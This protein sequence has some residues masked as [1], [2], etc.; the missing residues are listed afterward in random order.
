MATPPKSTLTH[1]DARGEARMVDVS[2]K[3]ATERLAVAEGC[4][5]MSEATLDLVM[6]GQA[7]KGDVLGTARIAGIMAAKRTSELIPL[8]HPLALSKVTVD[9]EPDA[10]LP[11]C[12]V[13]ATVKVT[14][15]TGVEMEALTAVSVACLT[16]Y[17]MIKAVERGARIDA[18]RL[19]EKQGGKSGH[20]KS[21]HD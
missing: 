5:V 2:D 6:S 12:R 9:I 7:K 4:V 1:I 13:T 21:G 8:C 11:G 19:I 16:I 18:I 3:P 20:Y 10:A 17:D 14:G 15:P